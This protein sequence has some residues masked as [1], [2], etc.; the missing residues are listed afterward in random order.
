MA[1][2]HGA[3]GEQGV[4]ASDKS[5]TQV[6]GAHHTVVRVR[7]CDGNGSTVHCPSTLVDGSLTSNE[8]GTGR[9]TAVVQ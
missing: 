8:D 3:G 4:N 9:K 2:K 6:G 7:P 1:A 5:S